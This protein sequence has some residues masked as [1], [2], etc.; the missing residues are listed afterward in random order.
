MRCPAH[1]KRLS[2]PARLAPSPA[3]QPSLKPRVFLYLSP[4]T[5]SLNPPGSSRYQALDACLERATSLGIKAVCDCLDGY[6]FLVYS[7]PAGIDRKEANPRPRARPRQRL[8]HR[9]PF[10]TPD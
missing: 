4:H 3:T 9:N 7:F 8:P 10:D 6:L 2:H 1:R 5:L